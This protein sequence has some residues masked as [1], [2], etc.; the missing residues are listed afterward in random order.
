MWCGIVLRHARGRVKTLRPALQMVGHL[1][2]PQP[3]KKVSRGFSA[4]C[5][6]GHVPLH[7]H[8]LSRF[9]SPR[10]GSAYLPAS[11]RSHAGR[12]FWRGSRAAQC[13]RCTHPH[14]PGNHS[15]NFQ[16]SPSFPKQKA[17]NAQCIG[18]CTTITITANCE[19]S[20]KARRD[21]VG[22]EYSSHPLFHLHVSRI[23]E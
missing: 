4:K 13:A 15:F 8:F 5:C 20:S 17:T 14:T 23:N 22:C 7:M 10:R 1:Y 2:F 18:K 9:L 11:N 16:A 19:Q 6:R 12:Y 3:K 21:V